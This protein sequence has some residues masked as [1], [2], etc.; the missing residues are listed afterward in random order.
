MQPLTAVLMERA[1]QGAVREGQLAERF[2]L[3]RRECQAA[4]FVL[5][6]MT[7]KEIAEQMNVAPNTVKTFLKLVM[8]KMGTSTRTGIAGKILEDRLVSPP[9][10]VETPRLQAKR[11]SSMSPKGTSLPRLKSGG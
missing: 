6:G 8:I 4:Q 2:N 9:G 10:M 5:Q 3:T 7:N 11:S 1:G